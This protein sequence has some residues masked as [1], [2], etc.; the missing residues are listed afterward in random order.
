MF[1]GT[2]NFL[3]LRI[4]ASIS[5]TKTNLIVLMSLFFVPNNKKSCKINIEFCNTWREEIYP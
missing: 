5:S 3:Y 4:I 1:R 2:F